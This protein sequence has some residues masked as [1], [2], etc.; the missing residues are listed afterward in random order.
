[1][2]R[3][4]LG[5]LVALN[6]QNV[7]V[8]FTEGINRTDPYILSPGKLTVLQNM[9]FED[10]QT[11]T[12]R[13]GMYELLLTPLVGSVPSPYTR[14][15]PSFSGTPY[16]MAQNQGALVLE[17]ANGLFSR[18]AFQFDTNDITGGDR[19]SM[20]QARTATASASPG[21]PD[22]ARATV[23]TEYVGSIVQEQGLTNVFGTAA[24]E[25]SVD[26]GR[27]ENFDGE[28]HTMSMWAWID[29]V[30]GG[31][32]NLHI[33]AFDEGESGT[34]SPRASR[35]QVFEQ[36]LPLAVSTYN[37]VRV[38]A[39]STDFYVLV[40]NISSGNITIPLRLTAASGTVA[41][42]TFTATATTG[43]FDAVIETA[44]DR[45]V[46]AYQDAAAPTL[47]I[48]QLN[49]AASAESFGSSIAITADLEQLSLIRAVYS[50]AAYYYTFY[51]CT[52]TTT[53]VR[54]ATLSAAGVPDVQRTVY[55]AAAAVGR[56]TGVDYS[57]AAADLSVFYDANGSDGVYQLSVDKVSV[58]GTAIGGTAGIAQNAYLYA[59][60][61]VYGTIIQVPVC[62]ITDT[63]G[64]TIFLVQAQS[65]ATGFYPTTVQKTVCTAR[66]HYGAAGN[67][68]A[69]WSKKWRLPSVYKETATGD[70]LMPAVRWGAQA[71]A[72]GGFVTAETQVW[73]ARLNFTS[74][75][76]GYAEMNRNT[77]LAGS[78]PQSF[79]GSFFEETGFNHRPY[80][81]NVVSAAGGGNLQPGTYLFC[82]TFVREDSHGNIIESAPSDV[83]TEV[84]AGANSTYTV[85]VNSYGL[86]SCQNVKT[87]IYRSVLAGSTL[88]L[89]SG[90]ANVLSAGDTDTDITANT[91]IYTDGDVLPNEP[92][93]PCRVAVEHDDRLWCAG[94]E[95]GDTIYFSQPISDDIAPEWNRL[96]KRRIPVSAGRVVNMVSLDD[97]L[98][99]FCEKRI[100]FI[101]GD[102]PTRTGAQDGYSEFIEAVSGY[103][104]PWDQP[105]S[106]VRATDGVWF[107][108]GFG[109]RLLG[110][111]MQIVQDDGND[112]ASEIDE[113]LSSLTVVRALISTTAQQV[114]FY[115]SDGT[116]Y[117][118]DM[119]YRQ[120]SQFTNFSAVDC[121][122]IGDDFYHLN[123][124][125]KLWVQ[126]KNAYHDGTDELV[127]TGALT[128]AWLSFA[129]LQG[130]Q[131]VS[132]I[133]LL[134]QLSAFMSE[135][136]N[137][138]V[139]A[140]Y[141]FIDAADTTVY[142]GPFL[143]LASGSTALQIEMQPSV[144]KCESLRLKITVVGP[145][146]SGSDATR[147]IRLTAVN[148]VV[149][150]KK[151]RYK[152]PSANKV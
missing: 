31:T 137:V 6:F 48:A 129:G 74:Q 76:L 36:V 25:E 28:G 89:D 53:V 138:T 131:R 20:L 29:A 22:F 120:W 21:R 33:R 96:L 133:M 145:T 141:N 55:T 134:G 101:Y 95:A 77:V 93:P 17:G 110:R 72:S 80:I 108:C 116:V 126:N 86:T 65:S 69:C 132:R 19:P 14:T 114:R 128:T 91:R 144:Q 125:P 115:V 112:L 135:N 27:I 73:Q 143:R 18:A 34:T 92:M 127:I 117:V 70:M 35:T 88:Y 40:H 109:F 11:I 2:H 39:S 147:T 15:N 50:G 23:E 44:N 85:T 49:A 13:R 151:G 5:V 10:A 26:M 66:I 75:D 41:Y 59:R 51:T 152:L 4:P 45:I 37:N 150:L 16:R 83:Y 119:L 106:I 57:A 46:I 123:S 81:T 9:V 139:Q 43:V 64:S 124:T 24:S 71:L 63:V 12:L 58:A 142:N 103:A 60:P 42:P 84:V 105:H 99:V 100:G 121:T 97:K 32:Q 52:G 102:G 7:P 149:G 87:R 56:I 54:C 111:N 67:L 118:Y 3:L 98:V 38:L 8:V 136:Y 146:G 78:C 140:A 68:T 30:P 1:M 130:F 79:D 148:L 82:A 47:R 90:V 122:S 94:A 113:A 104:I 62:F 107:R 61:L